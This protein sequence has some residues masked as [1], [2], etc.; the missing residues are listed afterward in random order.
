MGGKSLFF[1]TPCVFQWRCFGRIRN[2]IFLGPD[3]WFCHRKN[4]W[5]IYFLSWFYYILLNILFSS[6]WLVMVD[7]GCSFKQAIDMAAPLREE[8]SSTKVFNVC[9]IRGPNINERV[10]PGLFDTAFYSR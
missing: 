3:L 8:W 2:V 9:F 5:K 1:T 4:S 10:L 6:K 7:C